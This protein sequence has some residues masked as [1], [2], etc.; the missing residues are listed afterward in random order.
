MNDFILLN[1]KKDI[2]KNVGNF[3]SGAPLNS[4]VFFSY[5][6]QVSGAPNQ[7]G[8]KLSLKYLNLCSAKQR[9]SHRLGT[10]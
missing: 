10:I 3:S 9:N 6:G 1:T 4:I 5:Y 2:M 8:Y 7:P